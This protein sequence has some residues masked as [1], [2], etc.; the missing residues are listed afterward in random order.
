MGQSL[1]PEERLQAIMAAY[2]VGRDEAEFIRAIED[3]EI[4]GDTVEL[5]EEGNEIRRKPILL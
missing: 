2:G 4:D 5:D 1:T 3:G